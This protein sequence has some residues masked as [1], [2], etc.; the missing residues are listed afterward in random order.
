MIVLHMIASFD[1][2]Q[3]NEYTQMPASKALRT[4]LFSILKSVECSTTN[5]LYALN[6]K[7]SQ[8]FLPSP[9]SSL[10]IRQMGHSPIFVV[11]VPRVL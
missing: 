5:H 1:I 9:P 4:T 2:S 7:L 8:I 11:P 10:L 3:P 6:F